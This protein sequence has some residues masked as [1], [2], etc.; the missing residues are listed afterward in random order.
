M[1]AYFRGLGGKTAGML[2]EHVAPYGWLLTFTCLLAYFIFNNLIRPKLKAIWESKELIER[3]KF[4]ENVHAR[5]ATRLEIAREAQ[6]RRHDAVAEEAK[7]AA[8]EAARKK[9]ELMEKDLRNKSVLETT[10][11][12]RDLN[13]KKK[14]ADKRQSPGEFIDAHISAKPVVVF[15]KTWCSY[16]RKAK[17]ALATLRL[18]KEQYEYIELDERTDLPVDA[19]QDEFQKRY[20]SRSVPKVFIGGEFIGGGDDIARLLHEGE[21]ESLVE[22]VLKSQ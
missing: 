2:W 13:M 18:R 16:C 15:S 6:Q 20:G 9:L 11:I 19:I 17:A 4:D 3:K 8:E 1:T 14:M 7:R 12:S 22:A 21:L 5:I 10:L